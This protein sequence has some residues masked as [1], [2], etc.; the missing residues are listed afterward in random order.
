MSHDIE[1]WAQTILEETLARFRGRRY[2]STDMDLI[3]CSKE[4]H[5]RQSAYLLM[6][7]KQVWYLRIVFRFDMKL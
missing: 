6:I 4:V 7:P 5:T 1:I 3:L 2:I